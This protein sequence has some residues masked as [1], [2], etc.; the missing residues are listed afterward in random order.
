MN[1]ELNVFD[2]PNALLDFM[3]PELNS[4][5][6]LVELPSSCNPFY[7]QKVRIF[8]KLLNMLPLNNAKSISA[9]NM[10]DQ[11]KKSGKINGIDTLIENSS[12]N[13]V[14]SLATIGR[15]MGISKTKAFV[16]HEVTSGKLDLLRFFGIHI[17]VN[18]EPICPDPSDKTSGIY[19][20]KILANENNWL[21]P[22]QYD[23]FENPKAHEKITGPQLWNQTKEKMTIFCCGLGTTGTMVGTSNYLKK[24][25]EKITTVGVVRSPNNPVPGPRTRGLLKQIAFDWKKASDEVVEVGTIDSYSQSLLLCRN[26]ILAGPSSGFA[27]AGLFSFLKEK[28]ENNSLDQYRN[29]DGEIIACFIC[30]DSPYAYIDKYFE[31]VDESF[32]PPIENKQLLINQTKKIEKT[33]DKETKKIE[34]NCVEA[35]Q[36]F[37]L[38]SPSAI[39]KKLSDDQKVN[40]APNSSIVDVRSTI[41]FDHYHLP[42]SIHG[43][44]EDWLEPTQEMIESI[45]GKNVLIVCSFGERSMVVAEK[46][47]ENGINA[48]NLKGGALEWSRLH[49]PRWRA[50]VC[51]Q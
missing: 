29:S 43:S 13:T 37:Y 33:K 5:T 15:L 40:T 2:G 30:C 12:G 9:F 18:K 36:K 4:P 6:P 20:A 19:K 26:G 25:N 39:W 41:E 42:E 21:N 16:S 31:Y 1:Q 14:F 32:F 47:I 3:D 35:F 45:K 38:D 51:Y 49:L 24:Q 27:L 44:I 7:D 11:A 46:L 22:G 17:I 50:K 48:Y 28:K 8:A 34:L 23:N 10:L